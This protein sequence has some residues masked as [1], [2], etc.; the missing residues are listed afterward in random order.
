MLNYSERQILEMFKNTLPCN[1]YWVL[2]LI[3]NLRQA[4]EVA[5]R[6]LNE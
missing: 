4:L 2:F 3:E 1:L 5:R 6:I